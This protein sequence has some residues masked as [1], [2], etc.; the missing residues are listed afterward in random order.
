MYEDL[1]YE[2]DGPTAVITFNRPDKLNALTR[3]MLAEMKHAIAQAE[4][5]ENVI[6]IVI[7]G[8]GRGFTA[9]MDMQA[10]S[11]LGAAGGTGNRKDPDWGLKADPGDPAMGENFAQYYSYFMSVRK[12]IIGAIN[13]PCAGLGFV[14]AMLCDIRF[15]AKEAVMTGAFSQRGLVAEY[16]IS[17]LLPRLIGVSKTLD[18]LWTSKKISGEE[19]VKMGLA[20]YLATADTVLDEA[21][22]YIEDLAETAAP[23]SIMMMKRQVYRHLNME[24]GPAL[25]ETSEWIAESTARDDFKEG[26]NAYLEKRP[27]QFSRVKT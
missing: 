14:I 27:P 13:G 10:L 4:S 6:G 3:R 18:L 2:V 23:Y 22:A 15:V 24:L 20:D 11:D 5:D 12:P 19:A 25:E 9:G 21:K 7:T 1:K 8:E 17:W 26:V 16:G